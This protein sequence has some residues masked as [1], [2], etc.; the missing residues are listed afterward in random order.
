M[1]E[2]P[3]VIADSKHSALVKSADGGLTA[4]LFDGGLLEVES[5]HTI[6][7]QIDRLGGLP[8]PEGAVYRVSTYVSKPGVKEPCRGAVYINNNG[9]YLLPNGTKI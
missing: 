2:E 7:I 9:E 3:C 4:R 1:E 8:F 6:S 5:P